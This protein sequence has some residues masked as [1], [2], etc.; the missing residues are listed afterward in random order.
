MLQMVPNL[1]HWDI[2][3]DDLNFLD[4]LRWFDVRCSAVLICTSTV[5]AN[6]F[7]FFVF[8]STVQVKRNASTNW[9]ISPNLVINNQ[10]HAMLSLWANW[11]VTKFRLNSLKHYLWPV[12]YLL[13]NFSTL[14]RPYNICIWAKKEIKTCCERKYYCNLSNF[15]YGGTLKTFLKKIFFLP[16]MLNLL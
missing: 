9:A 4:N 5:K 10:F 15:L 14:F 1:I 6:T 7:P 2:I 11:L 13:I 8:Y 16:I 12:L 3:S